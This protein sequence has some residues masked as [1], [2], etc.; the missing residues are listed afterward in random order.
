MIN[1][2]LQSLDHVRILAK[3]EAQKTK[4]DQVIYETTEFR[5][6]I[7]KFKPAFEFT[8]RSVEFVRYAKKDECRTVLR[9][10]ENRELETSGSRTV[11]SGTDKRSR[12][13]KSGKQ[14]K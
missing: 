2:K 14:A 10:T 12:S 6:R 8:G 9:D 7:Y 4:C 1:F 5:Y 11:E 3:E 13:N